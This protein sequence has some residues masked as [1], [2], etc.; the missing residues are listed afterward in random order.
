ML[1]TDLLT[2]VHEVSE[3]TAIPWQCNL[4]AATAFRRTLK[5]GMCVNKEETEEI[6]ED[7]D[8]KKLQGIINAYIDATEDCGLHPSSE[9]NSSYQVAPK[10]KLVGHLTVLSKEVKIANI[11]IL[12][13]G[14]E[15]NMSAVQY[16]ILLVLIRE[17]AH[18]LEAEEKAHTQEQKNAVNL[19]ILYAKDASDGAH[20]QNL[21][22]SLHRKYE[23][24]Q[25]IE[26]DIVSYLERTAGF[27][28]KQNVSFACIM[29][30][31]EEVRKDDGWSLVYL[32]YGCEQGRS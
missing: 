24:V 26:V 15:L 29:M 11:R 2:A 7:N 32:S 17:H 27:E 20:W 12:A 6:K 4:R 23:A 22:K 25:E 8:G 31:D 19:Y 9:S 21:N 5:E 3:G 1:A 18:R 14:S 13:G 10:R 16:V 30:N 28:E